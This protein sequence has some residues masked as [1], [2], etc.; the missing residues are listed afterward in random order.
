MFNQTPHHILLESFRLRAAG[1]KVILLYPWTN[2]RNLFL[3][4]F[5]ASTKDGLLY[6][7]IPNDAQSVTQW[8]KGLVDEF[9]DVLGG[10]GQHTREALTRHDPIAV[11]EALAHDLCAYPSENTVLFLD[12]LDRVQQDEI[13]ARFVRALVSG[14]DGKTQLAVSSRLLTYEPWR[15]L[16]TADEVVILGTEH[17]QRALTFTVE[18]IP[19]PQLEVYGLGTGL[20]LINGE[21]VENWDGA[22]PRNLFFYFIDNPLA[23]R[24][25]IF[26]TFW[27]QLSTK[28]ATNV[29]H[30]TK[31]KIGERIGARLDKTVKADLTQYTNGFY[32]P[33]DSLVRHYDVTDFLSAVEDAA[34]A[35]DE[36]QAESLYA[37]AIDLYKAPFLTTIQM[38]WAVERRER[39]R[40]SYAQALIGVGR[41]AQNHRLT[42]HAL[43]FF[44]RALK[45]TPEREDIH[46]EM[47]RLYG[48]RGRIED[49]VLHYQRLEQYLHTT[50]GIPPALETRQTFEA[51]LGAQH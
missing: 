30:V 24:D 29:F 25:D 12:D 14:L 18:S 9:D 40:Q 44:S 39:L 41:I 37:R 27:P 51:V 48:E 34:V 6:Y 26:R 3:S 33:S 4:H 13:F 5:L 42:E 11:G 7:R 16:A 43:G 23:T 49:A 47:I 50:V 8:V 20:A 31:R 1:K 36:R 45:E 28:E 15:G 17:R 19:K 21:K 22:L 2:Y 46:R 35:T 38:A 10:F 32:I